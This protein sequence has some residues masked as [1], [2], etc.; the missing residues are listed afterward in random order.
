MS[1]DPTVILSIGIPAYPHEPGYLSGDLWIVFRDDL[2]AVSRRHAAG[3]LLH[4]RGEGTGNYVDDNGVAHEEL[5]YTVVFT[6]HE[7]TSLDELRR[8]LAGLARCYG[9]DSIALTIGQT[10]LVRADGTY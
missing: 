8:D 6:L 1:S 3:R 4:F 5:S 10:T 2:K 7:D 9:Q